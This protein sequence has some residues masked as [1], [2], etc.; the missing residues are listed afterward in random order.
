MGAFEYRALDTR[1]KVKKAV[2]EADSA[3]QVRQ[4]LRDKGWMPIAVDEVVTAGS[5][6]ALAFWGAGG[7]KLNGAELALVTRQLTTLIRSGLPVE[8]ALSAVAKQAESVKVEKIILSVR[9]RVLEGM[10]L[11]QSL[12]HEPASFNEM[13][14]ATVAA[15]E[16]SG[17]LEQVLE[18]LASYLEERDDTGKT[19]SQALVYPAFIMFFSLAIIAFL[20]TYV[21]PKVVDVFIEQGRELPLLTRI[22]INTSAF[23]REWGWLFLLLVGLLV[24]AL[25]RT[26]KTNATLRKKLHTFL[27]KTPKV[28]RLLLASDSA[29]L[30]STL[31]ILAK[32]GVPLVDALFIGSQVVMNL[33]VRQAVEEVA[34]KVRE[35]RSFHKAMEKTGYFPPMLV[36]MIA[37]GEMSGEL[38]VM[39]TRAAAYQERELRNAVTMMVSLLGPLMLMFMAGFVVLVVL[40]VMLP[41][42]QMNTFIG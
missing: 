18:Q 41:I 1:G 38:D 36:Q 5:G 27:L 33:A 15:G 34:T 6:T 23:S 14:R 37:S 28:G 11:A 30:A 7:K 39:L 25:V 29:R 26:L 21:V 8:Q 3:R 10:S 20:M 35:G 40:S 13:Y 4:Q 2:V 9:G 31:G 16:K 24:F 22:M 12:A 32:S 42:I 19:V 17:H